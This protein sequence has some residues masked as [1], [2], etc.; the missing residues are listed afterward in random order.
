MLLNLSL[1]TS[2]QT[3]RSWQ[4]WVDH[5]DSEEE[6]A[7][8]PQPSPEGC[9]EVAAAFPEPRIQGPGVLPEVW[10]SCELKALNARFKGALTRY[11]SQPGGNKLLEIDLGLLWLQEQ[12]QEAGH[13]PGLRGGTAIVVIVPEGYPQNRPVIFVVDRNGLLSVEHLAHLSKCAN[14]AVNEAERFRAP[15]VLFAADYAAT[16]L[17]QLI[18]QNLVTELQAF[19]RPRSTSGTGSE[20]PSTPPPNTP[21]RRSRSGTEEELRS[22]PPKAAAERGTPEKV[23]ASGKRRSRI[24]CDEALQA[25]AQALHDDSASVSTVATTTPFLAEKVVP[26]SDRKESKKVP[27][28]AQGSPQ[29]RFNAKSMVDSSIAVARRKIPPFPQFGTEVTAG[30]F[31]ACSDTD[32]SSSDDSEDSCSSEDSDP[33]ADVAELSSINSLLSANIHRQLLAQQGLSVLR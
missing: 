8:S 26:S 30:K 25:A 33:E 9:R 32:D 12:R 10:W 6:G 20:I 15:A 1:H 21:D 31:G 3:S 23:K 16:T 2:R 4:A 17:R 19:T 7:A 14:A 22:P 18:A 29:P 11:V 24:T 28:Q 5:S 13:H 27:G